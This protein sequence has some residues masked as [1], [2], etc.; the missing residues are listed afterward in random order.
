MSFP[1]RPAGR[2]AWAGAAIALVLAAALAVVLFAV[3]F[4]ARSDARNSAGERALS[5][6]E[7]AAMKAASVQ[8][9]N[10]L[11][12]TRKNFDADF[13][14]ALAGTTG[15]LHADLAKDKADTL[16]QLNQ[17][18]FD[19]KGTVTDVA[20]ESGGNAKS[21]LLVLVVAE[22]YKID[23]SGRSS[24]GLPQRVELTMVEKGGRW[25]ASDLK[26]LNLV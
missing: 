17:S 18:K 25:L 8:M 11:T 19:T 2:G 7:R 15:Q 22:G 16:G 20:L 4:P 14:R 5:A 13:A 10:L 23:D 12:Y 21:G 24:A 9:V 6:D 1:S 3:A 26:G